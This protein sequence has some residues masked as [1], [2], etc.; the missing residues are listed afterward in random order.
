MV[1]SLVLQAV[2]LFPHDRHYLAVVFIESDDTV[3]EGH[4]LTQVL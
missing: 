3:P 2:Q 1:E 4:E